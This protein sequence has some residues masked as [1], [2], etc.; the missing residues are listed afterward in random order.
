MIFLE[1]KSC[2][3]KI[4]FLFASR[5]KTFSVRKVS[6][7]DKVFKIDTLQNPTKIQMWQN[8]VEFVVVATY[9]YWRSCGYV[10]YSM[11]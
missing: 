9:V 3:I 10:Y 11:L 6:L 5:W 1:H 2:L 7:R 8:L 4:I